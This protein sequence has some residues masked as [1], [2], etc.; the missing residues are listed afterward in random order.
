MG[1]A[2]TKQRWDGRQKW[3]LELT[4]DELYKSEQCS[5]Q[6]FKQVKRSIKEGEQVPI[7]RQSDDM[8]CKPE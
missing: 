7:L 5:W 3:F 4:D 8:L 2:R 6:T 1:Q